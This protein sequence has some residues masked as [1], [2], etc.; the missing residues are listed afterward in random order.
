[1][2]LYTT[3]ELK[4]SPEGVLY[5]RGPDDYK[6]PTITDVPEEFNVSFLPASQTPLNIYSSKVSTHTSHCAV[7]CVRQHNKRKQVD[8][9]KNRC[10]PLSRPNQDRL[11]EFGDESPRAKGNSGKTNDPPGGHP[12]QGFDLLNP[13]SVRTL[14]FSQSFDWIE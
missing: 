9:I 1:M 14:I 12:G 13:L 6:I 5:S 4:Y 8:K 7:C 11:L 10:Q 3:E 2:G